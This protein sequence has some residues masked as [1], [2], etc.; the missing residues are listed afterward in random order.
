MAC[1]ELLLSLS[2]LKQRSAVTYITK[3]INHLPQTKVNDFM[4]NYYP[5]NEITQQNFSIADS[6]IFAD[7]IR[8]FKN[9]LLNKT[10]VGFVFLE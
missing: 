4:N 7:F 10:A 5:F 3:E 6:L 9:D 2:P 1:L 8:P